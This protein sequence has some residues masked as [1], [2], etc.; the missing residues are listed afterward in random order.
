M[1]QGA[2]DCSVKDIDKDGYYDIVFS[3]NYNNVSGAIDSYIYWGSES[4]YSS[5]DRTAL[6]TRYARGNAIADIDNDGYDDIVFCNMK[7]GSD[8]YI[9]SYIYWGSASGFDEETKT[10]L[11]TFGAE[12]VAVADV[13]GDG[14]L[15]VFLCNKTVD[16]TNPSNTTYLYWG[17]SSRTFTTKRTMNCGG[18]F[19]V[20]IGTSSAF[21][22]D[23][24]FL[25]S[26]NDQDLDGLPDHWEQRNGTNVYVYD[27]GE[28]PDNDSLDNLGEYN[29]NTN[30]QR[31]DTDNDGLSDGDEVYIHNTIPVE[32]DTDGDGINDGDEINTHNTNPLAVDTDNDGMPDKWEVDNLFNPISDDSDNDNDSDMLNNLQEYNNQTDPHNGDTDNDGLL[33]GFEINYQEILSDGFESG[34]FTGLNWYAYYD[35]EAYWNT[36]SLESYEGSFSAYAS[37]NSIEWSYSEQYFTMLFFSITVPR[38][39]QISFYYETELLDYESFLFYVNDEVVF[40]EE[41][42]NAWTQYS[43]SLESGDYVFYYMYVYVPDN[44]SNSFAALDNLTVTYYGLSP[45]NSDCDNDGFVDGAEINIHNTSPFNSDSD[46][47]GMEDKWEFDYGFDPLVDDSSTDSDND[48][49]VEY[50]EFLYRTN[51]YSSDT[52]NDGITDRYEI[53]NG[54]DPLVDDAALD[55]DNDGIT[56]ADEFLQGTSANN[57]DSD[58]DGIYDGPELYTYG[59]DPLDFDTDNDGLSDN[60]ELFIIN[61][62]VNITGSATENLYPAI[63][64]NGDNYMLTWL[65]YDNDGDVAKIL[66]TILDERGNPL[67]E[68]RVLTNYTCDGS[69]K[70][71]ITTESGGYVDLNNPSSG[72]YVNMACR[73]VANED[74]FCKVI[75]LKLKSTGSP[76]GV[77]YI[78]LNSDGSGGV[79]GTEIVQSGEIA[80]G[81]ISSDGEW[82]DFSLESAQE[83]TEGNVYWI[84]LQTTNTAG[85]DCVGWKWV[86][87]GSLKNWSFFNGTNWASY[88]SYSVASLYKVHATVFPKIE[89]NEMKPDICSDG[90]NYLITWQNWHLVDETDYYGI[91]GQLVDG[92]GT[93]LISPIQLNSLTSYENKA[94]VCASNG[95]YYLV[96]WQVYE[97]ENDTINIHYQYVDNEGELADDEYIVVEGAQKPQ[98]AANA[99]SFYL[100]WDEIDND[101]WT[102]LGASSDGSY[103][104]VLR[105]NDSVGFPGELLGEIRSS[106]GVLLTDSFQINEDPAEHWL[107]SDSVSNGTFYFVLWESLRDS[108]TQKDIYGQLVDYAGQKL[109]GIFKVNPISAFDQ[110][111]PVAASLDNYFVSAYSSDTD[112]ESISDIL[113]SYVQWG[114]STN[115]LA[116]DTD[117]DGMPDGWEMLNKLDALIDDS[118]NDSDNDGLTNIEEYQY[119]SYAYRTDTDYDGFTDYEE[120]MEIGTDPAS[121]DTDNDG[122]PDQWEYENGLAPLDNDAFFDY[123]NDGLTNLRRI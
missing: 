45:L 48:G 108:G 26:Q 21:G 4:G 75:S 107:H 67:I 101:D 70:S 15:D 105:E 85:T 44:D 74:Y 94:P 97:P 20:T 9:K 115:P 100:T 56:N 22:A 34:N 80:S 122:M 17:A 68:N 43:N 14:H 69:V 81:T 18:A 10:E 6:A 55:L 112:D 51:P 71:S 66:Y 110:Q 50:D 49:L 39:A 65:N 79:P 27:S 52:D 63:A 92:S 33:D 111:N 25:I 87:N 120:V 116:Y 5:S 54:T 2:I 103:Y 90:T 12:G 113:V 53:E 32:T 123:D 62:P 13:N 42:S 46:F 3:N 88:A 82:I 16:G 84:V 76:D 117:N 30:P 31:F 78:S 83:L 102:Y 35:N 60:Y 77:V 114:F 104:L 106:V 86:N 121:S 59:T 91:Y 11:Q 93:I 24:R 38:T 96:T 47:D 99:D 36:S 89:Y 95:S 23:Y 37:Q 40:E 109:H 73:F 8:Y 58:D 41:G 19:G 72:N 1:T 57:P 119:G 28:D 61:T 118:D 64:T 98:L 7:S 29:N